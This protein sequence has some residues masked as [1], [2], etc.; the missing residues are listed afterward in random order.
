[1]LVWESREVVD[2]PAQ[3]DASGLA[4]ESLGSS[5]VWGI[6]LAT[7]KVLEVA[8]GPG[9][10]AAPDISGPIVVWQDS[11]HSCPTCELDILARNI[12]TGDEF[13]IATGPADQTS[14][15]I[16]GDIVTWIE[17]S[18]RTVKL[19]GLN[20]L[21]SNRFE[22]AAVDSETTIGRPAISN[23]FVVWSE[24][25]PTKP[26]QLLAY[27]L[28][29]RVTSTLTEFD[30]PWIEYDVDGSQVTWTS[31]QLTV[32]DMSAS[33]TEVLAKGRAAGPSI[34]D[35]T[36]VWSVIG[37][38]N[39]SGADVYGVRIKTGSIG[40][41]VATDVSE[42]NPVVADHYLAWQIESNGETSLRFAP[43]ESA[44]ASGVEENDDRE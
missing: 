11:S 28:E 7:M 20:L 40:P 17:N 12:Q 14:P 1:M 19:L 23:R 36:V 41:L 9:D 3:Q 30:T 35:G 26:H 2:A 27:N 8:H 29:T 22:F 25:G 21:D 43:L 15:A 39:G 37:A 5:D 18:G 44:F 6:N 34:S 24:I 10:Q 38:D 13:P 33:S 31:P 32:T 16:S 42:R 4:D